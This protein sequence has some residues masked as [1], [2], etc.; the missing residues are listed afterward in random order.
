MMTNNIKV[1][2]LKNKFL[3]I[4]LIILTLFTCLIFSYN[5]FNYSKINLILIS[6]TFMVGFVLLYFALNSE[7]DIHKIALLY[8]L[9][10][11]L[12]IAFI[13]T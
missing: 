13:V 2:F 4:Y 1:H 10:F 5:C 3:L 12:I 7:K 11:G 8:L 6:V 9:I